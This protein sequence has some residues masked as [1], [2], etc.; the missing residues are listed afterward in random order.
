M[1]YDVISPDKY[2]YGDVDIRRSLITNAA[3]V[4]ITGRVLTAGGSSIPKASVILTNVRGESRT[5]LTNPFGYYRFDGLRA[6]ETVTLAAT[7]KGRQ[8]TTRIITVDDDLA[9]VNFIA[10]E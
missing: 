3:E 9:D 5:A 2:I 4:S 8:F 10:L 1:D 7:A 6:G